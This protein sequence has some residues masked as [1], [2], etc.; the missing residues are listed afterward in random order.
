MKNGALSFS[1]ENKGYISVFSLCD[2]SKGVTI[3]NL[4][5]EVKD[6]TIKSS[7]PIGISNEFIGKEASV[8]VENG[9]L[10]IIYNI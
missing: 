3:E 9:T 7:M 4:K 5:Y 8:S 2:E 6:F 1:A 10:L